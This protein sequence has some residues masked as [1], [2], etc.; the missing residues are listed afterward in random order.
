VASISVPGDR[1]DRMTA[2]PKGV[3]IARENLLLFIFSNG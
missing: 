3:S 1:Q 2:T